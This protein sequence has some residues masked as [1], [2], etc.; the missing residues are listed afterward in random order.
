M[1][2]RGY[3]RDTQ[4]CHVKAKELRQAHQKTKEA[5]SRS[6]SEPHTCCFY[7]QQHGILGRDPTTTP[8]L[9]V[10]TCKRGVSRNREEDFVDEEEEEEENAQQASGESILPSNQDL[11]ITLEPIPSPGGIP[12]PEAGEGTSGANVSRFPLSSPS[13]RLSQIR[14]QKNRTHDDMFYKLM[15]S[16]C[17]DRAQLNAWRHSVLEARK[18]LSEREEQ[19]Q[20][21]KKQ[22]QEVMLKLMVEQRDMMK[23]LVQLQESQQEHRPPAASIVQLRDILPTFYILLTQ[24]PKNV[25]GQDQLMDEE[26]VVE[27]EPELPSTKGN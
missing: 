8:P 20:E 3:K 5:N 13:L 2:D 11:F 24:M 18:A 9:S 15:Q 7:D 19:T 14:R 25:P 27:A 26:Q 22:R 12:D 16:S 1:L 6:G 17:T 21:H 23:H 10:D 4:Q